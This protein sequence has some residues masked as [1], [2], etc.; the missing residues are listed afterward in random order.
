MNKFSAAPEKNIH[1]LSARV[2]ELRHALQHFT[3]YEL[4][5]R[6]A[7]RYAKQDKTKGIFELNLWDYSIV[8]TY[9]ELIVMDSNNGQELPIAFQALVLYYFYTADG[10]KLSDQWISFSDLQDGRFYS[11]AFQGYTGHMLARIFKDNIMDF[12]QAALAI[13]GIPHPIGDVGYII[14]LFPKVHLLAL[15]WQ[16]DEDFPSNYQIL[17][18]ASVNHY[19]PTDACAIAG[20]MLTRKIIQA[21]ST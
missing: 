3:P 18:N 9:P 5:A 12:E 8:I 17:F 2:N 16:G 4:A 21:R 6:T 20:S 11:Q 14:R 15:A 19:L 7:A 10:A 13:G 1:L